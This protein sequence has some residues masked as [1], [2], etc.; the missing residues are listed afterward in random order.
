MLNV[1]KV[2]LLV[3]ALTIDGS[4]SYRDMQYDKNLLG[5]EVTD[6]MANMSIAYAFQGFVM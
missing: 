5:P 6:Y 3:A 1:F 4:D 2:A